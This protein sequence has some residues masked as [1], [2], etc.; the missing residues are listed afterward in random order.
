MAATPFRWQDWA[1]LTLG[2][3]LAGSPWLM[4]YALDDRAAAK[5]CG[6]G[7]VLVVFNL[8]SAARLTDRGQELFNILLGGWLLLSP[9]SLGFA[10]NRPAEAIAMMAGATVIGLA[11]WQIHDALR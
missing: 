10:A 7:V 2:A 5:A 3:G 6:V 11:F 9:Y 4:G 1:S 8:I